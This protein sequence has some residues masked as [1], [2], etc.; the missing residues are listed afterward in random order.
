M[1]LKLPQLL[2]LTGGIVLLYAAVQNVSPKDVIKAILT[3]S[4][5][6]KST[7]FT[8]ADGNFHPTLPDSVGG[9]TVDAP[10]A[11]DQANPD[12]RVGDPAPIGPD[13]KPTNPQYDNPHPN[14]PGGIEEFYRRPFASV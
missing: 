5:L 2:A 7:G 13:G 8:D 12:Y 1:N 4:P 14:Q 11:G 3:G 6:P 10:G 9:G